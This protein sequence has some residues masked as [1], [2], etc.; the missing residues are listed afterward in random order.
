M[1][2]LQF[3]ASDESDVPLPSINKDGD[4]GFD[5]YANERTLI[6]S[7]DW[8]IVPTGARVAIPPG[9]VGQIWP[10]SG[11]AAKHGIDT[12]AG[13]IDANFRGEIQVVMFNHSPS[14]FPIQKGDRIAQLLVVPC[15]TLAE[16]VDTIDD[17]NR[18]E[19]GFGSTGQ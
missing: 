2:S 8:G 5:L 11:H 15:I 10:R 6:A 14:V 13:V 18:G 19:A 7:G 9:F 1:Q 17:T 16:Y 3:T 4:A 12:G